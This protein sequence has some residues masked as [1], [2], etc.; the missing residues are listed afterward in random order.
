MARQ[1]FSALFA[2]T[3]VLG[4]VLGTGPALSQV[5][6]PVGGQVTMTKTAFDQVF[7][8]VRASQT[9]PQSREKLRNSGM[10]RV[11]GQRLLQAFWVAAIASP[12]LGAKYLGDKNADLLQPLNH[13]ISLNQGNSGLPLDL[14]D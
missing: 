11:N 8:D 9:T 1:S 5:V 12:Y 13:M 4:C 6:G 2:A 14:I 7:A 3:V 10:K